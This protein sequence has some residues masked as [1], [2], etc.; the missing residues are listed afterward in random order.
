[1]KESFFQLFQNILEYSFDTLFSEKQTPFPPIHGFSEEIILHTEITSQDRQYL[2]DLAN[3]I[4]E[5]QKQMDDLNKEIEAK[6]N[7]IIHIQK[8]VEQLQGELQHEQKD[9][10]LDQVYSKVT[11][12]WQ[13]IRENHLQ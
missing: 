11:N 2:H 7:G 6:R 5:K 4:Q 8:R 9:Q 1:M 3:K 13:Q 10:E 12:I